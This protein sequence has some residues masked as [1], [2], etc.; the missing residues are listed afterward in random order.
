[1]LVYLAFGGFFNA[2]VNVLI[3]SVVQLAVRQQMRGKVLGLLE[4]LSQGLAPIGIAV[5]DIL[6]EFPLN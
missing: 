4:T 3:Q 2:I 5:V 6:G 1:M